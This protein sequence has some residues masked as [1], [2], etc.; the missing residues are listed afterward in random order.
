MKVHTELIF[1]PTFKQAGPGQGQR[2]FVLLPK[3][4]EFVK[5]VLADFTPEF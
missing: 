5:A 1:Y 3:L 4:V 2:M